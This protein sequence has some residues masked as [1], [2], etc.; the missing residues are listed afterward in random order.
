MQL[1]YIG[2]KDLLQDVDLPFDLLSPDSTA[3]GTALSF[4][5]KFGGVFH[6]C[7]L[8]PAFLHDSKLAAAKKK[9]ELKAILPH[10]GN[11]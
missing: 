9:E 3:A 4:L 8:L 11:W 2:V 6:P 10:Q 1:D 7:D 5:D